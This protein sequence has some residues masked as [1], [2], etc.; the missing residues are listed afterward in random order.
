MCAA[1][2]CDDQVANGAETD[3]DC[4]G[5][6]CGSCANGDTCSVGTDC[7]SGNCVDGYC[8]D[9]ACA[10]AC[11]ACNVSGSEGTC[12]VAPGAMP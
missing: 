3:V 10:A 11:R 1:P 7:V 4:G 6:V 8:C 2:A 9:N 12:S 5:A